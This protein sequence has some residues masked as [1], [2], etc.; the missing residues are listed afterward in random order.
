MFS[1]QGGSTLITY[2]EARAGELRQGLESLVGRFPGILAEVRGAGLM[3][4]LRCEVPNG[5]L[6]ARLRDGGLLTVPAAENV[7]RLL[8][9]LVIERSH[10][11]EAL[12]IL[13]RAC[14]GWPNAA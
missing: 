5:E 9:P 8:P 14:A 10:I 3:L 2:V 12:G 1:N 6:V 13:D 11:E 7:V 4:G